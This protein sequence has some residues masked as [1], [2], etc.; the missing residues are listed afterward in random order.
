MDGPH[1][2]ATMIRMGN[3]K[4]TMRMHGKDELYDLSSDPDEIINQIDNPV[5][6]Q[7]I[8]KMKLRMLEWYQQTADCIPSRKDSR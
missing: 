4:Y 7:D 1:A 8:L 6:A 3:L 5:Y 2:R